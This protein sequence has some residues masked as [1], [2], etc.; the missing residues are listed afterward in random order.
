MIDLLL[1]TLGAAFIL[2]GYRRGL[3]KELVHFV[4]WGGLA[5]LASVTLL[6]TINPNEIALSEALAQTSKL[7]QIFGI[8]Y[9]FIFILEKFV[10]GA[11]LL[12]GTPNTA[13]RVAGA[14]FGGGKLLLLVFGGTLMFQIYSK[15][16]EPDMPPLLADS[17]ILRTAN[18][19]ATH[20]YDWAARKGWLNYEKVIWEEKEERTTPSLEEQLKGMGLKNMLNQ[21]L[22]SQSRF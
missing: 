2:L 3:V 6:E 5:L 8:S 1:A 17:A 11:T 4:L 16:A 18:A 7:G 21:H 10:L 20:T 9:L 14:A 19:Q 13:M 22:P 15:T 12:R